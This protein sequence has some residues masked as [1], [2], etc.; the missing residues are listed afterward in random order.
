MAAVF[1]F[2][3][4]LLR[5]V[6]VTAIKTTSS[7]PGASEIARIL[8]HRHLAFDDLKKTKQKK[9]KE[10]GERGKKLAI[11]ILIPRRISNEIF[12]RLERLERTNF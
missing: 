4:T 8:S 6:Q 11:K 1:S 9:K 5:S 2:D 12:E 10:G 3:A 7:P